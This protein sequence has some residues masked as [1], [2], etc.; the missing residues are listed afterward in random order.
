MGFPSPEELDRQRDA[1][2]TLR[3]E[4]ANQLRQ[5]R[6]DEEKVDIER[7]NVDLQAAALEE[8]RQAREASYDTGY[9]GGYQSYPTGYY[10]G[11]SGYGN[12]YPGA[13]G[14]YGYGRPGYGRF[15]RYRGYRNGYGIGQLPGLGGYRSTPVG[16]YPNYSGIPLPSVRTGRRPYVSPY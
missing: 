8:A 10:G 6:L 11:Y 3:I 7:R 1:D 15:G 14:R 16:A 13:Y 12:Y 4:L 5:A 9:Y 2:M